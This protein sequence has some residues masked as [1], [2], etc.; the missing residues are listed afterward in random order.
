MRKTTYYEVFSFVFRR[1]TYSTKSGGF[2]YMWYV[3][4]C[5]SVKEEILIQSCKQHISPGVLRDAFL[6][7]CDR[8]RRYRGSWHTDTVKIF[9]EYIFLD[10]DDPAQLSRELEPYREFFKV[11]ESGR[12]LIPV[13]EKEQRLLTELADKRHH[14][15]MSRGVIKDGVMEITNGPLTGRESLIHKIDR[16][17]RTALLHWC[18]SRSGR[19]IKIGL[20]ITEKS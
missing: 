12:L 5:P 18:D 11:M 13:E 17:K 1:V 2:F 15:G 8:M 3:V 4:H 7:T 14:I 16:H 20:E 9:P 10:S 6:L 19:E